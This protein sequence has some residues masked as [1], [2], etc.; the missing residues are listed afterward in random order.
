M[1]VDI[2]DYTQAVNVTGGSVSI[3]GT[4]TVQ[5]TGT[6]TVQFAAGQSVSISGTPAVTIA[7]GSVTIANASIAVINASGTKITSSRPPADFGAGTFVSNPNPSTYNVTVPADIQGLVVEFPNPLSKYVHFKLKFH[8]GL[9]DSA[10]V[11]LELYSFQQ[12]VYVIPLMFHSYGQNQ[13]EQHTIDITLQ[14]TDLLGVVNVYALFEPNPLWLEF[15]PQPQLFPNQLP[16]IINVATSG[17]NGVSG[18]VFPVANV[19]ISLFDLGLTIVRADAGTDCF[20]FYSTTGAIADQATQSFFYVPNIT[21]I[22][23]YDFRGVTLPRGMGI[24]MGNTGSA[25]AVTSAQGTLGS[26]L[27]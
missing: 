20:L 2:P 13:G 9:S 27:S 5:I 8:Y 24:Y 21:G 22:A 1:A 23:Y 10:Y 3:T 12:Q 15:F 4:A 17:H 16:T 25:G 26:S 6:P 18:I 11:P 7:S 14:A 19:A